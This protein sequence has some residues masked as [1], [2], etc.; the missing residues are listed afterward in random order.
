M[1]RPRLKAM[2]RKHR[3]SARKKPAGTRKAGTHAE[4]RSIGSP[5][6]PR[7][8]RKM[9]F[10]TFAPDGRRI[11]VPLGN[12]FSIMDVGVDAGGRVNERA[13]R[14]A[15]ESPI[16]VLRLAKIL[17]PASGDIEAVENRRYAAG[18]ALSKIYREAQIESSVTAGYDKCS[19]IIMPGQFVDDKSDH[20]W[21]QHTRY[22]RIRR[23]LHPYQHIVENICCKGEGYEGRLK[24]R[25]LA[26]LDR[27]ADILFGKIDYRNRPISGGPVDY[28]D[29]DYAEVDRRISS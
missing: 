16:D 5:T 26:G 28:A 25:L 23:A 17:K 3:P 8:D 19:G 9:V 29:D 13:Y 7:L 12:G 18:V 27:L 1:F 6:L 11:D 15:V 10:T 22:N 14:N 2:S 24:D 20:A 4:D 21:E